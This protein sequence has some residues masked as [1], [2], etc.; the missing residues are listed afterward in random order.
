MG[1]LLGHRVRRGDGQEAAGARG[2]RPAGVPR[3]RSCSVTPTDR[4]AAITELTGRSDAEIAAEL[5]ADS[6]Y[7]ELGELDAQ[8]AEHVGCRLPARL[9]VRTPLLRR[10]SGHARRR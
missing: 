4:R 5:S 3:L 7:T 1:P 10:R 8:R 9:R 2:G 6:G